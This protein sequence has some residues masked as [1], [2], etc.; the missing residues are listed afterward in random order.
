[1][2]ALRVGVGIEILKYLGELHS[3]I[4]RALGKIESPYALTTAF[5]RDQDLGT[6]V[7]KLTS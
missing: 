6:G 7:S 1:V 3:P 5:T 4:F 2:R